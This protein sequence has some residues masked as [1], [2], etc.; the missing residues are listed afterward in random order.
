VENGQRKMFPKLKQSRPATATITGVNPEKVT[1][2][3]VNEAVAEA[4]E[5]EMNGLLKKLL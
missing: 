2:S 3:H 5:A 4:I 1:Q